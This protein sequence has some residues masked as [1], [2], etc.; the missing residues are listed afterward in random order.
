MAL[1]V[2][3]MP[4]SLDSG[5][6]NRVPSRGFALNRETKAC[7]TDRSNVATMYVFVRE[8]LLLGLNRRIT[9]SALTYTM[10]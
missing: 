3:Y 9:Q 4:Y 1:T 10:T 8:D 5:F 6:Q 7:V 2:S